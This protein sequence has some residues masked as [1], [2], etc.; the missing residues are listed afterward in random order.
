MKA[1]MEIFEK[2][3]LT[4]DNGLFIYEDMKWEGLFS[5]KT[6]YALMKIGPDAFFCFN[7]EPLIL[8]FESPEN[9]SDI[10]KK[11]WNFNKA[12]VIIVNTRS[13]LKI[14]NGF[15][16]N[17]H[18]GLL[19]MLADKSKIKHFS[20]WNLVTGQLW[21]E[22]EKEFSKQKRLDYKLLRNIGDARSILIKEKK[23]TPSI[24]N[25][26]IGRLVFT[27]YL[28]DRKI[29]IDFN[30]SN[31][32]ILS[33]EELLTLIKDRD[34][35]YDFFDFLNSRF[36]GDLFPLNGEKYDVG[37]EHLEVLYRLFKGEE[38]K[39]R[40]R[41]LF[42]IY[43]F[44]IIPIEFVSNI[45]EYFIGKDKQEQNKSF[46]TPPF[47]VDYVL[48]QT[49]GNFLKKD[50]PG[51]NCKVLDP[52]CGSGIFLVE[53]LRLLILKS[54]NS[55][56]HLKPS[57]PEFKEAI[58]KI[59]I[60]NI[61]GID[62]DRDAL[63]IAAFSLYITM[64]DFFEEPR[65]INGFEFPNLLGTNLIKADF[66]N[67]EHNFNRRFGS[68]NDKINLDFILGNPPWGVV[69]SPYMDYINERAKNEHIEIKV[70]DR[71][72]AQA[73]MVR[74]SDFCTLNTGCCLIVSSKILYNL[75]A[76]KFRK[77]FLKNFYIDEVFEISSV[78]NQ[79]FTR[80][81]GPAAVIKYRHAFKK[82]TVDNKIIHISLKPNPFFTFFKSILIDKYDFKEIK[83]NFLI[84]YDWLWKV[85]VYGSILDYHFIKRLRCPDQFPVTIG[86]VLKNKKNNLIF[87]EGAQR[88]GAESNKM[89]ASHLV[90]KQFLDTREKDLQRYYVRLRKDC[91]WENRY[92]YRAKKNNQ[93]L[94]NAPILLIKSGLEVDYKLVAAISEKDTV[95]THSILGI[96]SYDKKLILEQLLGLLNSKLMTYYI[97]ISGSSTGVEREQ[98]ISRELYYFPAII[99]EDVG[100]KTRQLIELYKKEYK[101]EDFRLGGFEVEIEAAEKELNE[102]IFELYK[103][104]DTEKDLLDYAFDISI[105]LLQDKENKK[106]FRHL[107]EDELINY[108]GLFVDH[109]SQFHHDEKNGYFQVEIYRT[110]AVI[111]V[112]FKIIPHKPTDVITW[113]NSSK[114][115]DVIAMLTGL[116]FQK[117]SNRLFIQKDVKGIRENSFYVIKPNQYKLWHPAIARLDIIEFEN[118]MLQSQLKKG[119]NG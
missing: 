119:K 42:S 110:P 38:I 24:A 69:E 46:Y 43:N 62:K 45:Y 73:F 36:K 35:L 86:S 111:A 47:L 3:G 79:I 7:N 48:N 26:L 21:K 101:M 72:I 16:F 98:V 91:T 117:V 115:E 63:E 15:S 5:Q 11:C 94:F 22:Y 23:L 4:K 76:D 87:G 6:K 10:H 1:L 68:G 65:D 39:T 57:Q 20:Y 53:A 83:Q 103:L 82:E 32:G 100:L 52:A 88:S 12:P 118:S 75:Q 13:G 106:P 17:V 67:N 25:K 34:A 59:L 51:F 102:L 70:S 81:V 27:R 66:F 60:D 112:N 109:F 56:S 58:K 96:K 33:N 54:R 37:P 31:N 61:F 114:N 93:D 107:K 64:L 113:I 104:T 9:E 84:Q 90:G 105:P 30:G 89:D 55:N 8:F 116:S 74:V 97:F 41:S 19:H 49:V 14:Y 71:Q 95:F 40:Q 77:Y 44:D 28:I 80:A 92:A 2:L 108:T 85:L 78:R 18:K 99:A 50:T 29:K